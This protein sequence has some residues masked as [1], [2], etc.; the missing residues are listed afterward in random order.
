[1]SLS[2][3]L[4]NL[5]VTFC[6][7]DFPSDVSTALQSC[8]DIN[9]FIS[10]EP[11][12]RE[13]V[14][15]NIHKVPGVS[16]KAAKKLVT[17]VK[18]GHLLNTE[19][20]AEKNQFGLNFALNKYVISLDVVPGQAESQQTTSVLAVIGISKQNDFYIT[21]YED[22]DG[23]YRYAGKIKPFL[24]REMLYIEPLEETNDTFWIDPKKFKKVKVKHAEAQ[25]SLEDAYS[26]TDKV[27]KIGKKLSA[28]AKDMEVIELVNEAP[29]INQLMV[30]VTLEAKMP[31]LQEI[32]KIVKDDKW[33]AL[34]EDLS[35]TKDGITHS[36]SRLQQYMGTD[37]SRKKKVRV[38]NLLNGVARGGIMNDKIKSLQ[39]SLRKQLGVGIKKEAAKRIFVDFDGTITEKSHG[40]TMGDTLMPGAAESLRKL[41]AMGYKIIIFS[42]RA[43]SEHGKN[44][45]KDFMIAHELPFDDIKGKPNFD[46]I[47]DDKAISVGHGRTWEDVLNEVSLREKTAA[48]HESVDVAAAQPVAD[49][50]I[51]ALSPALTKHEFVGALRRKALTVRDIDI[52]AIGNPDKLVELIKE[53]FNT[54]PTV[55]GKSIVRFIYKDMLIDFFFIEDPKEWGAALLYRTGPSTSN[56]AM[57]AKAKNKGW[58]LNEHGLF[59]DQDNLIPTKSEEDIYKALEMDYHTPE[60]RQERFAKE[61]VL[62][63]RI[64]AWCDKKMGEVEV[65]SKN[66]SATHGI[67]KACVKKFFPEDK[68]K[69]QASSPFFKEG[70]Q[71]SFKPPV[72]HP[73]VNATPGEFAEYNYLKEYYDAIKGGT[74]TI[75]SVAIANQFGN[76]YWVKLN[77]PLPGKKDNVIIREEFLALFKGPIKVQVTAPLSDQEREEMKKQ[78]GDLEKTNPE[79]ARRLLDKYF[80]LTK[81]ADLIIYS[82]E[83][84]WSYSP[85][86][87]GRYGR[88]SWLVDAI[89][90]QNRIKTDKWDPTPLTSGDLDVLTNLVKKG[91]VS[92]KVL[93]REKNYY[94]EWHSGKWSE[95]DKENIRNEVWE[96]VTAGYQA[97][98]KGKLPPF[99]KDPFKVGDR[100]RMT[101]GMYKSFTGTVTKVDLEHQSIKVALEVFGNPQEV[102]IPYTH[103][104]VIAKEIAPKPEEP[105]EAKRQYIQV[106]EELENLLKKFQPGNWHAFMFGLS[107]KGTKA[108]QMAYM[109]KERAQFNREWPTS[110]ELIEKLNADQTAISHLARILYERALKV[111]T[112]EGAREFMQ[113]KPISESELK[114][115]AAFMPS[116]GRQPFWDQHSDGGGAGDYKY[117]LETLYPAEWWDT[118]NAY[119]QMNAKTDP[120]ILLN[121]L[122]KF[123]PMSKDDVKEKEES[124]LKKVAILEMDP[125][126]AVRFYIPRL[127]LTIPDGKIA[128]EYEATLIG[129]KPSID[130]RLTGIEPTEKTTPPLGKTPAEKIQEGK[131][132]VLP[133]PQEGERAPI[134]FL[135]G[136]GRTTPSDKPFKPLTNTNEVIYQVRYLK[137][138][139]GTP[140]T[141]IGYF[142]VADFLTYA[143]K[144]G[145][146]RKG[147]TAWLTKKLTDKTNEISKLL[148]RTRTDVDPKTRLSWETKVLQ[149]SISDDW[150]DALTI[151]NNSGLSA[152]EASPVKK[153][154][155]SHLFT[156]LYD[157]K[158]YKELAEEIKKYKLMPI[159]W[160]GINAEQAKERLE[161]LDILSGKTVKAKSPE[162]AT[163]VNLILDGDKDFPGGGNIE[164]K[165]KVLRDIDITRLQEFILSDKFTK[166]PY[167]VQS[168]AA[169]RLE[170][171]GTSGE[172]GLFV[173]WKNKDLPA[174][175]RKDALKTLVLAYGVGKESRGYS[176]AGRFKATT[177]LLTEAAS[178]PDADIRAL[179]YTLMKDPTVDFLP[180]TNKGKLVFS[181]EGEAS[182]R[183][184]PSRDIPEWMIVQLRTEPYSELRDILLELIE[185]LPKD[186]IDEENPPKLSEDLQIAT[187]GKYTFKKEVLP[188]VRQLILAALQDS[189]PRVRAKVRSYFGLPREIDLLKKEKTRPEVIEPSAKDYVFH[190]KVALNQGKLEDAE[191]QLAAAVK[192]NDAAEYKEEIESLKKQIV[193]AREATK[194]KEELEKK[195]EE[196][197]KTLTTK[198]PDL[199]TG[200]RAKEFLDW[201]SKLRYQTTFEF[202][203]IKNK[204]DLLTFLMKDDQWYQHWN[205]SPEA[206]T[207]KIIQPELPLED[208]EKWEEPFEKKGSP[209]SRIELE[210]RQPPTTWPLSNPGPGYGSA[211]PR[212]ERDDELLL[213][214]VRQFF[215][216]PEGKW[217]SLMNQIYKALFKQEKEKNELG[218]NPVQLKKI[219][220]LPETEDQ[221]IEE[222]KQSANDK[223]RLKQ[224]LQLAESKDF[225][226]VVLAVMALPYPAKPGNDDIHVDAITSLYRMKAI[227]EL[228]KLLFTP[229]HPIAIRY[230]VELG[231]D[232]PLKEAFKAYPNRPSM[233]RYITLYLG[234]KGDESFLE[235]AMK[236][237]N[238]DVRL[239][240]TEWLKHFNKVDVLKKYVGEEK[241]P[242]LKDTI[243]KYL[244]APAA[245]VL[246]SPEDFE[247]KIS[248][249]IKIAATAFTKW[250]KYPDVRR[251][252]LG[253]GGRRYGISTFNEWKTVQSEID[254]EI[255]AKMDE[256]PSFEKGAEALRDLEQIAEK[257]PD[258]TKVNT[259]KAWV[260]EAEEKFKLYNYEYKP[261]DWTEEKWKEWQTD[262]QAL[263]KKIETTKENIKKFE[264]SSKKSDLTF[265]ISQLKLLERDA[266][267]RWSSKDS[268]MD[269]V[270]KDESFK[271]EYGADAHS[272]KEYQ[273]YVKTFDEDYSPSGLGKA[274]K[275]GLSTL[276]KDQEEL[277]KKYAEPIQKALAEEARSEKEVAHKLIP[278]Y[279]KLK[280]PVAKGGEPHSPQVEK[281]ENEIKKYREL[282]KQWYKL[283]GAI[284][285]WAEVGGEKYRLAPAVWISPKE[286]EVFPEYTRGKRLV[287]EQINKLKSP[288]SPIIKELE[289]A[290]VKAQRDFT[291]KL[292]EALPEQG[293]EFLKRRDEHRKAIDKL[294]SVKASIGMYS[295]D[296]AKLDASKKEYDAERKEL[297]NSLKT[298][299]DLKDKS[300]EEYIKLRRRLSEF[301]EQYGVPP[302]PDTPEANLKKQYFQD[303]WKSPGARGPRGVPQMVTPGPEESP[304]SSVSEY[305]EEERKQIEQEIARRLKEYGPAKDEF[306]EI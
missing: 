93:Q 143:I 141:V 216:R 304:Y 98:Y 126:I 57:R 272:W 53:K 169:R 228:G 278:F 84:E 168:A 209:L 231:Q 130:D 187:P 150:K 249:L 32:Q 215:G 175:I 137:G 265:K 195:H 218:G 259:L 162:F 201:A 116:I 63:D 131:V 202:L 39:L 151:L 15:A 102:L 237:P 233:Q 289:A 144:K 283:S 270:K 104:E 160:K 65:E 101:Q 166:E 229:W 90:D 163:Q 51:K 81:E 99:L 298:M 14:A 294:E 207:E 19:R 135:P 86:K 236:S 192:A 155:L 288:W 133:I 250:D 244:E 213:K 274:T 27:T 181:P 34:R 113:P 194:N 292:S 69:K 64:C 72:L 21:A 132:P 97:R 121:L 221:L 235:E 156:S 10:N 136:I 232:A 287:P 42:V 2:Y 56:I 243:E 66:P 146:E 29:S 103:A 180:W 280:I 61:A 220:A 217:R 277:K 59:D 293:K 46:L 223:D 111:S 254:K 117:P 122:K 75:T 241:D 238:K 246:E 230:L 189:D 16:P 212:G 95:E 79:E 262:L 9:G 242:T 284:E 206:P 91:K 256:L 185:E 128:G 227:P 247:K 67:C 302:I 170:T 261:K 258:T 234:E 37:P 54:E 193:E 13:I 44:A 161:K 176:A 129:H 158:Q 68:P 118:W 12:F 107:P 263:Q 85:M 222:V 299:A 177:N 285:P 188:G 183:D 253:R 248:E 148:E 257:L 100:V 167:A 78:I 174:S 70:D 264:S 164:A 295:H 124:S 147:L 286:S 38:L 198:Y 269:A 40:Y 41:K 106:K 255:K 6:I 171:A 88:L 89:L 245:A 301:M 112:A 110:T 191:G 1:M 172:E 224:I 271:K 36:L 52:L 179:A 105:P 276:E 47:I 8:L 196:L 23:N 184:Q 275:E 290:K 205:K 94:N 149:A 211:M 43:N 208:E 114:T 145:S 87:G 25:F 140:G 125:D 199:A 225:L 260:A 48:K 273:A 186:L 33:Q 35:W 108:E 74:G 115:D 127:S 24:A 96:R 119:T 252:V 3:D 5:S 203:S 80:A 200:G 7:G 197:Q 226:K 77:S 165:R 153:T 58:K 142:D 219:A 297:L 282:E 159:S 109:Y 11:K 305:T 83:Y 92:P 17:V 139:N 123:K 76:A 267:L 138:S 26:I 157:S 20:D 214:D 28:I 73:P 182:K 120:K 31:S 296:Q 190:A 60:E 279:R 210:S 18:G 50:V 173:I 55:S 152:E 30:P 4:N 22:E 45:I 306:G 251:E 291:L 281:I 204:V 303:R 268:L 178:D 240:A 239:Q 62:R 300:P 71:V 49:E 154:L 82:A 266:Q 134:Y